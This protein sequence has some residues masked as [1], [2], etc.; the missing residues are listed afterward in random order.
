M[1]EGSNHVLSCDYPGTLP[2]SGVSYT[3]SNSAGTI[4]GATAATYTLSTVTFDDSSSFTC[5]VS[6][7][8]LASS[9]S[10]AYQVSG[11]CL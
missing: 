6:V 1:I 7:D 11:E 5:V 9:S 10:Q 4:S 3:W 2:A 8:G